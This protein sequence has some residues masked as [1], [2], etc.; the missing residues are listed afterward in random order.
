MTPISAI[1]I[2][3]LELTF[4]GVVD[5]DPALVSGGVVWMPT[6]GDCT[7]G[8]A[9]VVGGRGGV[10]LSGGGFSGVRWGEPIL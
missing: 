2:S 10:E 4:G 6:S 7:L 8:S 9:L 3:M 1:M 5:R